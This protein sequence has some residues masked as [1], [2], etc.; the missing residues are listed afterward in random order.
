MILQD[1]LSHLLT[2]IRNAF[3]YKHFQ[4]E[5]PNSSFIRQV[6]EIL[7]YQG[8]IRGFYIKS[9]TIIVFLKYH[10]DTSVITEISRV[11][12]PSRRVYWSVKELSN[13][14]NPGILICSTSKGIV[15]NQTAV[16]LNLGGEILCKIK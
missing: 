9:G 2:K 7:Y 4:I 6:V 10:Q 13:Y 5:H 11:S 8:Y 1:T 3:K 15:S 16:K 12:K 14:N